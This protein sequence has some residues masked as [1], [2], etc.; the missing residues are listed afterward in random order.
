MARTNRDQTHLKHLRDLYAQIG[1]IPSYNLIA[2]ALGFK[3]KNAAFKLTKRL[4]DT[5]HLIKSVGGRLAPGPAFF[6]LELSDDEESASFGVDD[7]VTGL[8]RAQ[9]LDRLLVAKPSKTVLVKV[10][11]DSMLK[12]GIFSGDIAVV[13]VCM[14]AS[15]GDI[16]VAEVNGSHTIREFRD[17]R[18]QPY[19]EKY[20]ADKGMAISEEALNVV[21]IVKG[22][23]R[24]YTPPMTGKVGGEKREH[25]DDNS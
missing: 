9:A 12:A 2:Q 4:I 24:S 19:L 22:I 16:V 15:V 10:R 23:V 8:M 1:Y 20:G 3:A 17:D 14:H 7:N 11:G 5:G 6:T 18:N 21:G 25:V 13:E